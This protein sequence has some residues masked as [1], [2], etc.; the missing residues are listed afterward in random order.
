MTKSTCTIC[1]DDTKLYEYTANSAT[2][3]E[4]LYRLQEW[5]DTWNL[6]FN[7]SKYKVLHIGKDNPRNDH[8][9]KVGTNLVNVQ[10]CTEEKYL[11]ITFDNLMKCD[12]HIQNAVSKANMMFGILKRTFTFLDKDAFFAAI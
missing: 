3:Q 5:C 8:K 6:Y 2:I 12:V 9:I 4:D 7:T 1:A 11:E 10:T